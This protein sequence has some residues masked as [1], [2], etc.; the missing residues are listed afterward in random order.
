M[1]LDSIS[2]RVERRDYL[3]VKQ[4][5]SSTAAILFINGNCTVVIDNSKKLIELRDTL[6]KMIEEFQELEGGE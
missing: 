1:N 6:N 4:Y 5:E 3:T 2:Y